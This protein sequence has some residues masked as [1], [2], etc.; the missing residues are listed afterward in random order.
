M[1]AVAKSYMRKNFLIYEK[2]RKYLVIYEGT[3]CHIG[4]YIRSLL[5]FLIYEENFVF[6][7]VSAH[8]RHSEFHLRTRFH[9]G[10]HSQP[11][12]PKLFLFFCFQLADSL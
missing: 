7:F 12:I 5:D 10:L 3:V 4:L 8:Y 9:G 2:M 1:G 11:N 6:F